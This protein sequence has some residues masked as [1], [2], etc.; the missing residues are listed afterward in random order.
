MYDDGKPVIKVLDEH[1]ALSTSI[2]SIAPTIVLMIKTIIMILDNKLRGWLL[3]HS[4]GWT[5]RR[6]LLRQLDRTSTHV[7]AH[8]TMAIAMCQGKMNQQ[9]CVKSNEGKRYRQVER[10]VKEQHA[11]CRSK[12]TL[13]PQISF[14]LCVT[15]EPLRYRT[16]PSFHLYNMSYFPHADCG[17]AG[18]F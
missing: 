9:K 17:K 18:N 15:P 3:D 6:G 12:A 14:S 5:L 7:S 4:Q 10:Q 2:R 8:L 16:E 11:W 13:T 1:V